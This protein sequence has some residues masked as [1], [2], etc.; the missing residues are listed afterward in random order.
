MEIEKKAFFDIDFN[1][2]RVAGFVI[3]KRKF[4]IGIK[5]KH[6]EDEAG[7]GCNP[8]DQLETVGKQK[9]GFHDL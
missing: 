9:S 2:A 8:T 3:K 6:H 5:I 7:N 1:L 4:I